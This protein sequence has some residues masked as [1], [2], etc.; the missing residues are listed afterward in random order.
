MAHRG[1]LERGEMTIREAASLLNRPR[2]TVYNWIR[3]THTPTRTMSLGGFRMILV[4]RADILKLQKL[5]TCPAI[6]KP[7]IRRPVVQRPTVTRPRLQKRPSWT[8]WG[9]QVATGE[10]AHAAAEYHRE[11]QQLIRRWK[12]CA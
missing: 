7:R 10:A 12:K 2:N 3:Q 1:Y 4:R 6:C 8:H 9:F 5:K 11:F